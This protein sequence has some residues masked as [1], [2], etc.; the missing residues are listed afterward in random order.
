MSCHEGSISGP[1]FGK[2]RRHRYVSKLSWLAFT[3]RAGGDQAASVVGSRDSFGVHW[4]LAVGHE[5]SR[6]WKISS[7]CAY[8]VRLRYSRWKETKLLSLT[9]LQCLPLCLAVGLGHHEVK[10]VSGS[11][12]SRLDTRLGC[13]RY[14][15]WKIPSCF[16][17]RRLVVVDHWDWLS[18]FSIKR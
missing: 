17:F 12:V 4:L 16:R 2:S 8:A 18:L 11:G 7:T 14:S 1:R 3:T 5:A 10:R 15:R 6:I 13:L 9:A